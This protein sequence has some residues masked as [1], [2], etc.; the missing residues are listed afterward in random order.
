M[1][2]QIQIFEDRRVR[3]LWD[4]QEEDWY[5][6]IVDVVAILTDQPDS[7]KARG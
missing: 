2:G 4:E 7:K 6:S 5:F 3:T 1:K